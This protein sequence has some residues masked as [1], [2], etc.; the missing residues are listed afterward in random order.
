MEWIY[1]IIAGLCEVG[2]VI[3][4]KLS[5]GFTRHRYTLLTLIFSAFSFY[6]LAKALLIIPI[7]TGY[8]IWTG[9]GAAGSV[10][11]GIL[12]FGESRNW[13]RVMFLLM[14]IA[15]VVGLKSIG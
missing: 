7:G 2:F 10:I 4:M 9:I 3:F 12:F 11:L 8:G 1:L 6:F 15:G 13:K 14:I 5:D